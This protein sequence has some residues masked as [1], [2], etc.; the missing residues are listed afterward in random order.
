MG[1]IDYAI[2]GTGRNK[3]EQY[4]DITTSSASKVSKKDLNSIGE[5]NE[6][7]GSNP[8][9]DGGDF[10][11]S[12]SKYESGYTYKRVKT[13]TNALID[14]KVMANL[15]EGEVGAP[16]A[17]TNY[18]LYWYKRNYKKYK[19][20][21]SKSWQNTFS[22]LSNYMKTSKTAG[23][24]DSNIKMGYE[25]YI[26]GCKLH[27]SAT[28]HEGTHNGA[29]IVKEIDKDRPCHLVV[30]KHRKYKDHSV[31]A[32]GYQKYTY[33][34]FFT[35]KDQIYI[36]IA[37]GWDKRPGRYVWGGCKGYWNYVSINMW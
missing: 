36:R 26:K 25:K 7:S 34:S 13:I 4:F 11:T 37:D 20:L 22:K 1:G 31:L 12:P 27:A 30:H 16:T 17:A 14:Y 18:M 10:I 29:D 5:S 2:K 35:N 6:A 23:T 32:V 9:N 15:S 33:K 19:N 21:C 28:L 8:P 3:K 24:K